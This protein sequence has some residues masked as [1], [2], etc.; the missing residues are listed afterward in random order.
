M[1]IEIVLTKLCDT[2]TV[3]TKTKRSRTDVSA[4][5]LFLSDSNKKQIHEPLHV[6]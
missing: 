4:S 1:N 3:L 6:I 2:K 5:F